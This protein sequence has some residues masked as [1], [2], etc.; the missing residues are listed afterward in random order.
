MATEA[1]PRKIEEMSHE[2]L[3]ESVQLLEG[4]MAA[5]LQMI[6]QHHPYMGP[7][8]NQI[9]GEF[10]AHAEALEAKY[11]RSELILPPGLTIVKPH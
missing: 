3:V 11:P 2:F 9:N 8:A 7:A 6:L 5:M 10:Q 4:Y 1:T